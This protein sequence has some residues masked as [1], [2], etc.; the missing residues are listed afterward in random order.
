MSVTTT[1]ATPDLSE[2]HRAW[3]EPFLASPRDDA[4][5]EARSAQTRALAAAILTADLLDA[6]TGGRT[7][8]GSLHLADT[9]WSRERGAAAARQP[10]GSAA[11]RAD[12]GVPERAT[13]TSD[14]E[15][16]SR[17]AW[18]VCVPQPSASTWVRY[19]AWVPEGRVAH[20]F[21]CPSCRRITQ[22]G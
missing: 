6:G 1:T 5:N 9:G 18:C 2:L 7:R 22:T 19:E 12:L 13:L 17:T 21:A 15:P 10:A 14:G 3:S 8:V 16:V 20:G 4:A 11:W